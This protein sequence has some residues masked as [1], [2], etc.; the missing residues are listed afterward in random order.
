MASKKNSL[1]TKE[2]L[3]YKKKKVRERESKEKVN[4]K[5]FVYYM[6][7]QFIKIEK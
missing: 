5:D 7:Q 1:S 3:E 4:L 6:H 2:Q